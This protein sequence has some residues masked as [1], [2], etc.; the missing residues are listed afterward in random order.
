MDTNGYRQRERKTKIKNNFLKDRQKE[1]A[2][3]KE[4]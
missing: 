4:T 1:R 2:R 3:Q